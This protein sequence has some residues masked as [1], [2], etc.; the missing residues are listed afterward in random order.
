MV[1]KTFLTMMAIGIA[2]CA[3]KPFPCELKPCPQRPV[4]PR[5]AEQEFDRVEA[6]TFEKLVMREEKLRQYVRMLEV[7]C[8]KR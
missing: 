2:G 3:S 6:R 4:L 8:A 7:H 5:I 1:R